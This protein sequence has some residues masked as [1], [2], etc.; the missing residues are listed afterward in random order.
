MSS[1][2]HR[3]ASVADSAEGPAS[4]HALTTPHFSVIVPAYNAQRTLPE[5]LDAM[6]AQ[7]YEAWECVVIDDGSTDDTA[8][9][10]ED[11]HS[12]DARFRLVQ[13]ENQGTACANNAGVRA[14]RSDLLVGCAAD[15]YLLPGHLRV[16]DDLIARNP[17]CGIFTSNG[18]YL[19]HDSGD[20]TTVYRSPEWLQERSVSF[21]E[22]ARVCFYSV[23]AVYRREA[24]DL[25]GGY[26]RGVYV[27]DYDLWLRTMARGVRHRYTPEV[28]SVHRVSSFQQ[29]AKVVAVRESDARVIRDVI[30]S[31]VLGGAQLAATRSSLRRHNRN[32]AIRKALGAV[33]GPDG[34]ER[35]IARVRGATRSSAQR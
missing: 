24:F 26:R 13:Q 15:D 8:M 6:L 25:V 11:Y 16:M 32:I 31:G 5:T 35:L 33:L 1:P 21:E 27:D 34:V 3:R 30:E 14:A 4:D 19:D 22:L 12:R 10:V 18:Q 23:G 9:L 2:G 29:S 7:E 17:D 20:F 28:L